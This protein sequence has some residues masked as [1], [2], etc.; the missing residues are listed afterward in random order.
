MPRR[1]IL[2]L[3]LAMSASLLAS[4]AASPDVEPVAS[5]PGSGAG[6]QV[7]DPA[8]TGDTGS[9]D[10]PSM[11]YG[12]PPASRPDVP[13]PAPTE[14]SPAPAPLP[15]TQPT[16]EGL[17]P[18]GRVI[19][20]TSYPIPAGAVFMSPS[21]DDAGTGRVD[22]PVRSLARAIALAPSGGT[23]VLRGGVHRQW[24]SQ[25]GL[26]RI[27][28]KPLTFQAYPGEQVWFDGTDV[29]AD[30]WVQEGGRWVRSW[31][32]PQFCGGK[33]DVPVDGMSPVSPNLTRHSPCAYS[34]SIRDAAQP[35]A[36]DPQMAFVNGVEL[37]QKGSL[38]E[39]VPG[40]R[41]F[42]YDWAAKRIHIS[43]D[44]SVNVVEL[45]ARP[46][47]MVLGGPVDF[48]VRG[49]GF[50]RYASSILGNSVLFVGLG[51]AGNPGK[52]LVENTVFTQNA[53][54]TLHISGPK[55]GTVVTRSV[56]A[57][58]HFVG[59]TSNGYA[60][61]NPGAPNGLLIENSVFNANNQGLVD[62]R[63]G[64][65][66]GAA[67]VKLAHMTGF[68]ARG[69]VFDNAAGRAPG[70][71]CDMDCSGGVIVNN[72][73]RNNG[74]HGIF[75]E[76]SNTGIIADNVISHNAWSGIAV[77]SANTKVYNNTI[78][79]RSG[80]NVQAVWIF[81]DKRVAPGPEVPWPYV[82]P[83]VDLGPNTTNTEFANNLIVAQ[84][85]TGARLLNF[86]NTSD[87]APNTKVG[88]YFSVLDHNVYFHLPNQS[89]YLWG[90]TDAIKSPAQLASVSGQP[91][92]ANSLSVSTADDPLVNRAAGNFAVRAGSLPATT[93][94]RPLPADV[95]AAM[96][97]SGPV[98]RGALG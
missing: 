12:V 61:S 69:N 42:F 29:V 24:Y 79:N 82:S 75:Y 57:H 33:Y 55:A 66:C 50:R 39:V 52:L 54:Q 11:P 91:W 89:L 95:A 59:F 19:P 78:I 32:T 90:T 58:N 70:F 18:T 53:G 46:A 31:S 4:C 26:V 84:Q 80:P 38:A 63:C 93:P 77:A 85:P 40:S 98:P 3:A 7:G 92:E 15:A 5:A 56:F 25:N 13:D 37:T 6:L 41:S 47:A 44:P 74:A 43:E 87:V 86:G 67:N 34:D 8:G 94:G 81:D 71:W 10:S 23:I 72:V 96:G 1:A 2:A 28:S 49:I 17:D 73:V 60:N 51:G 20:T 65:S 30:G 21:G 88:Q 22:S 14:P 9:E 62:T 48:R 27:V 68:V 97:V 45:A 83:R 64:A 16:V 35:V 36:G 76:I